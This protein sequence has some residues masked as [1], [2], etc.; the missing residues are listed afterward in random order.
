MTAPEKRLRISTH[1][2]QRRKERCFP[3]KSVYDAV[4]HGT[5]IRTATGWRFIGADRTHVITDSTRTVVTTVLGRIESPPHARDGAGR[6][7]HSPDRPRTRTDRRG[8]SR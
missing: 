7:R 2:E 6:S 5:A 1:A 8:P 4:A 3:I